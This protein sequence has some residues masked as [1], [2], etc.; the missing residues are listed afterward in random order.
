MLLN[1]RTKPLALWQISWYD[2]SS[3]E[4]HRANNADFVAKKGLRLDSTWENEV[5]DCPVASCLSEVEVER[6]RR[7]WFFLNA[8]AR[9]VAQA[10]GE[11]S[12]SRP[13]SARLDDQLAENR[14]QAFQARSPVGC[15]LD[16]QDEAEH[17]HLQRDHQDELR[18]LGASRS[19]IVG[20]LRPFD[21][22]IVQLYKDCF[23]ELGI[24]MPPLKEFG[25]TG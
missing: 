25:V 11:R 6:L 10:A 5:D 8:V 19:G 4:T 1:C 21:A 7:Y 22:Q 2:M 13:R 24:R 18:Q 16:Q 3:M 9:I 14:G 15:D 20:R 12:A 17:R 23:N